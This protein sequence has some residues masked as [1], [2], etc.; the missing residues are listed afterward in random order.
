[1]PEMA[2]TSDPRLPE[3][4]DVLVV[5][6][7]AGGAAAAWALARHGLQVALIDAG[8]AFSAA[9]YSVPNDDW[10]LKG[11]PTRPGS[12]G[13]YVYGP[14]QA[15]DPKWDALRSVSRPRHWQ[16]MRKNRVMG[17]YHH[18]RGIGGS[19]LH[20]T[21]W[22]HRLH[23]HAFEMYTRFGVGA[24]WPLRYDDL[25]PYYDI[26]ERVIG[27]AGPPEVPHR[28]RRGPYPTSAHPMSRLSQVLREG[29]RKIG[30][31][32]TQNT[33]AAPSRPY[34]GRPQC[35]YC[36]CCQWGCP[37]TDKGSADVTFVPA[38]KA[39][40]RCS[41]HPRQTLVELE[42]GANDHIKAAV[43]ADAKGMRR[44]LSAR[45]I[46][47]AAGAVE[48]PRLLLA[49]NGLA[50]DTGQVGRN[51]MET[52][53]A[54]IIGLHPD[55]VGSHRGYPEDSICWDLNAPD[56]MP[57][58]VGGALLTPMVASARLLGPV[59]YAVRLIEG[60][61]TDHK[62]RLRKMFGH[63]VG[64]VASCENLPNGN[65]FIGLADDKKDENGM[66]LARIHSF[67]PD[68][69]IERLA[70]A[71]EKARQVLLACGVPEILEASSTY[72][73]F[74]ATHVFGSCRMGHDPARS[75]VNAQ[76]RS[77]R[78]KNLWITDGSVFPTSGG[79]EG[80][81]L[82]IHALAIRTADMIAGRVTE[83][84]Q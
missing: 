19:T 62:K 65:S 9:D 40:G 47:L 42:R 4:A 41:V 7:G 77:H 75:V 55:P 72:E 24:D 67:L 6:A 81:A 38:A 71:R 17:T 58:I 10:E 59:S 50:N 12:R 28:P 56:A 39:T 78:W 27:V 36:G 29:A 79:G 34:A 66:P 80:P 70:H 54:Y 8:P 43:L 18:V 35:N 33:V 84:P 64:I 46:V 76:G 11:F 48:T 14:G 63:A 60:F 82:T 45:H 44:R 61:G 37:I 73:A 2:M 23:P 16:P 74:S 3:Q 57:N 26:A 51:F 68:R 20:F 13:Q 49:M 15:L 83:L 21:G 30:L 53:F 25:A 1:M 22:M 69:E 32:W 52:L 31:S 5:G